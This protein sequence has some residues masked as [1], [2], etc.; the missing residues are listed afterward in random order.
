MAMQLIALH[1][2]SINEQTLDTVNA[3]DL[4]AFLEVGRDFNTWI[5]AR[6]NRYGFIE[7]EDFMCFENLSSPKRGSSKSR[8]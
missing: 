3:R 6:I 1:T 8:T 5:K 2:R 4:H 7:D